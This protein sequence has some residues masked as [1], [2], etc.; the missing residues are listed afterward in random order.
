MGD[1]TGDGKDDVVMA[2]EIGTTNELQWMVLETAST[3][4]TFDNFTN[5]TSINNVFGGRPTYD[6][7]SWF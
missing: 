6:S 2:S 3:G 7:I 5:W 1:L 4:T